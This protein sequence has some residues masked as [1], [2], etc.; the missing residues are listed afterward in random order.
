MRLVYICFINILKTC[1]LSAADKK[2]KK[3]KKKKILCLLYKIDFLAI[4]IFILY[5]AAAH[6]NTVQKILR[7][8]FHSAIKMHA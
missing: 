1:I 7:C 2:E 6:Q 5:F 4:L 3:L 8:L